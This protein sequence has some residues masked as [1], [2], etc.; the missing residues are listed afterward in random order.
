MFRPGSSSY[1]TH[2]AY[3]TSGNEALV[4]ATQ[5]IV[6]SFIFVNGESYANVATDRWTKLTGASG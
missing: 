5:N 4:A 6:T 1:Y 3:E 2:I